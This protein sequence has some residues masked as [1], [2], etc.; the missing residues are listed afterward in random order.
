MSDKIS[1]I[2]PRGGR[3]RGIKYIPFYKNGKPFL[4]LAQAEKDAGLPRDVRPLRKS[5][6]SRAVASVGSLSGMKEMRDFVSQL[7][8]ALRRSLKKALRDK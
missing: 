6:T 8:V 7:P 5:P 4:S 2:L 1:R 3:D